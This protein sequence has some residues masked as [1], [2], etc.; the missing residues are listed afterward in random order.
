M[1]APGSGAEVIPFLKTWVNLPMAIGFTV[2]Y[3]KLAN[4][5]ST[6]NLFYACIIPFIA[7]FAAFAFILYPARGVL[8]PT[9]LCDQLVAAAPRLSAPIAILRNWTYCLFYVMAGEF[10]CFYFLRVLFGVFFFRRWKKKCRLAF[11][12]PLFFSLTFFSPPP[13]FFPLFPSRPPTNPPELWGSVVVSVL[14]WGFANQITTVDE[15]KTFYPFFGLGANVA[16]IFSGRAVKYFSQVRAGLPAGVDGWGVSLRGMMSLVVGF[17]VV[18]TGI[19]W[20]LN[21]KVVPGIEAAAAKSGAN[22]KKGGKNKMKENMSVGDSFKFLA[23]SPYIRDLATLVVAY[24]ISINLVEV[25]GLRVF[26]FFFGRKR[27]AKGK[28]ERERKR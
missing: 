10:F 3:A 19:F 22:A 6:E 18:I 26:F 16:L 14:F 1:T 27:G 8:H 20:W 21:R 5:L 4:V 11:L 15:A 24:G 17:G 7:F 2:I 9:A 25:S 28:S 13:F 23:S 12:P